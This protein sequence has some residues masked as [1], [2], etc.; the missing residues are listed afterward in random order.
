MYGSKRTNK[1]IILEAFSYLDDSPL[2]LTTPSIL[3]YI[4]EKYGRVVTKQEIQKHLGNFYQRCSK[5]Y[6]KD[7]VLIGKMLLENC[8]DNLDVAKAVL[9][10]AYY[11]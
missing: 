6:E 4:E 8:S 10:R 9:T 11:T 3:Q 7:S 1:E 5:H 2:N